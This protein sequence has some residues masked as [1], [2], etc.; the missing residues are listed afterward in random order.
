MW[1]RPDLFQQVRL[2]CDYPFAWETKSVE[3]DANEE[4]SV[5]A[6]ARIQCDQV[7]KTPHKKQCP[8]QQRIV[9]PGENAGECFLVLANLFPQRVRNLQV[10]AVMEPEPG[11][12]SGDSHFSQLLWTGDR[13]ASQ[14]DGIE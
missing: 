13:Q 7:S 11:L 9:S 12:A 1:N 10:R 5:P 8:E 4:N 6:K 14:S 3:I 2:E